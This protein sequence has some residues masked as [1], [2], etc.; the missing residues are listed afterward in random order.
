MDNLSLGAEV[1]NCYISFLP[2]IQLKKGKSNGKLD[3]EIYSANKVSVRDWVA[4]E[5]TSTIMVTCPF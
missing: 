5:M 2:F 4:V 1:M 3:F